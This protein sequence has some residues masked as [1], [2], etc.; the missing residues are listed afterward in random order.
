MRCGNP[1]AFGRLGS[2]L[3]KGSRRPGVSHPLAAGRRRR[4]GEEFRARLIAWWAAVLMFDR[5]R[6][7]AA[8]LGW[9]VTLTHELEKVLLGGPAAGIRFLRLENRHGHSERCIDEE[10]SPG[11]VGVHDAEADRLAQGNDLLVDQGQVRELHTHGAGSR[12]ALV[13]AWKVSSRDAVR[14]VQAPGSHEP[15]PYR[16]LCHRHDLDSDHAIDEDGLVLLARQNQH[17]SLPLVP[18]PLV[19]HETIGGPSGR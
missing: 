7:L 16:S 6:D 14:Q 2:G 15:H 3:G 19:I 17:A 10:E 5:R 11:P 13:P 18:F 9:P 1:L 12:R 8:I 4:E